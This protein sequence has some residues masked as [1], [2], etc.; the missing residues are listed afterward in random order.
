MGAIILRGRLNYAPQRRLLRVRGK[1]NKTLKRRAAGL[2]GEEP[3]PFLL[4]SSVTVEEGRRRR[5]GGRREE[6]ERKAREGICVE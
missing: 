6:E 1:N 2:Y 3:E 4:F 5:K